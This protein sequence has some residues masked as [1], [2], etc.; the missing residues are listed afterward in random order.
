MKYNFVVG[1][2]E[3]TL[4]KALVVA[5]LSMRICN[6]PIESIKLLR[7]NGVDGLKEAK[8]LS[9]FIAEQFMFGD[10][11]ELKI[12]RTIPLVRFLGTHD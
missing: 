5:A 7:M 12:R 1:N 8:D 9:E 3:V 4:N 10:G 11:G 6:N 2:A